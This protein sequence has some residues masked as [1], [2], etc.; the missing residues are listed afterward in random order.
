MTAHLIIVD[1]F[2][3]FPLTVIFDRSRFVDC[4]SS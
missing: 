4:C 3:V 2:I 1:T